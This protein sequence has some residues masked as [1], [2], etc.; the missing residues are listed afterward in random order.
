M[1]LNWHH[2]VGANRHPG[3][4]GRQIASILRNRGP[5]ISAP[6]DL[7]SA[8][9]GLGI[10]NKTALCHPGDRVAFGS[11]RSS[12]P[13]VKYRSEANTF[14][15]SLFFFRRRTPGPPRRVM[16]L[17]RNRAKRERPRRALLLSSDQI[18][19]LAKAGG[20]GPRYQ[21]CTSVL[22]GADDFSSG[23]NR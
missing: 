20:S 14:G 8:A 2:R 5:Q 10:V 21:T 19:C 11:L 16:A 18:C 6:M 15:Y 12:T 7:L 9:S 3:P 23:R 1:E 22:I 17:L 4:F 13:D